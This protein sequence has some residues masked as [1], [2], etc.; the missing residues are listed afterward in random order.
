M[1]AEG[2]RDSTSLP[3][4]AFFCLFIIALPAGVKCYFIVILTFISLMTDFGAFFMC[5]L[6]ILLSIFFGKV[7]FQSLVHFKNW[8]VIILLICK[9]LF[10]DMSRLSNIK[11]QSRLSK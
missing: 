5:I 10:Q 1:C 7:A 8:V 11:Y 3:T 9:S 2:S 4:F 6:T